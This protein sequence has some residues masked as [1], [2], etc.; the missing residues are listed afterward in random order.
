MLTIRKRP[1]WL[2]I[3]REGFY[4][5]ANPLQRV[6]WFLF[7]PYRPGAKMMVFAQGKLLL[8]KI[9]YSHRCWVLPG[10]G[11]N[12]G[13]K[14]IEAAMRE[15]KEESGVVVLEPEYVGER[16][17]NYQY[18]R[19]TMSY[20]TQTINEV[21]LVIDGQ[22]ITNAGWFDLDNLPQPHKT[23]LVEEIAM[24]NN[25]KYGKS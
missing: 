18:K 23:R 20:F 19:V 15:L 24:Y 5:I 7:R 13:E 1:W 6:Y 10:G 4:A 11:V 16:I 25:W 12:R 21:D 9:G 8:V 3:L 14:P 22:E 2:R 17:H